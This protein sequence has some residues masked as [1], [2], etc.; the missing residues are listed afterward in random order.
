M[1]KFNEKISKPWAVDYCISPGF[2]YCMARFQSRADGVTYLGSVK[3][4]V[5]V[6]LYPELVF[7]PDAEGFNSILTEQESDT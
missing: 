7:D 6:T 2:R 5:P 3:K 4:Q 1:F